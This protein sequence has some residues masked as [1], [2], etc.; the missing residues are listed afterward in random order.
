MSIFSEVE[1]LSG[2]N[3]SSALLRYLIFNSSEVRD[4]V[5][6][7]LSDESPSGPISYASH[8]ACTTEYPTTD[9]SFESKSGRLDILIQTDNMAIGIENKFFA[10][11]QEGQPQKYLKSLADV[12]ESLSKI[13]HSEVRPVL[14]VLCPESRKTEAM[15]KTL[16]FDYL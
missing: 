8:F 14:Y 7:Y 5:F 9:E 1:G 15:K 12:S 2:E 13:S 16:G 6:S 4:A 10:E 11:F 3:L